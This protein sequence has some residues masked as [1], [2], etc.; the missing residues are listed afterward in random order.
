MS[1]IV[2]VKKK[3][4]C[5]EAVRRSPIVRRIYNTCIQFYT[6]SIAMRARKNWR[7]I[8]FLF[9]NQTLITNKNRVNIHTYD[10]AFIGV[11]GDNHFLRTPIWECRCASKVQKRR[12]LSFAP[13]DAILSYAGNTLFDD[14]VD[15]FSK[16]WYPY[17]YY[18]YINVHHWRLITHA[19]GHL[20]AFTTLAASSN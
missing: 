19:T 7:L 12:F 16:F 15:V 17:I 2:V 18:Y 10:A 3:R 8:L 11:G 6:F 9:L 5:F 13:S 1:F 4:G 14:H 20:Y